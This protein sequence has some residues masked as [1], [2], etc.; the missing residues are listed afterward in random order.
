MKVIDTEKNVR[1]MLGINL[2]LILITRKRMI[3]EY[4]A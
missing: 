4:G 2:I 1:L 3:T